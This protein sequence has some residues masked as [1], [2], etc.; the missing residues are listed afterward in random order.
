ME[1]KDDFFIT[2]SRLPKNL[3]HYELSFKK[4]VKL[5][6]ENPVGNLGKLKKE[7]KQI[8]KTLVTKEPND[9]VNQYIQL[10]YRRISELEV[11]QKKTFGKE[12][13][14]ELKQLGF[15]LIGHY[16]LLRTSFYALE[17]NFDKD[18]VTI[19]FGPRQEK[20]KVCRLSPKVV[21]KKL[22]ELH[23]SITKREFNDKDFLLNLY[24]ACEIVASKE[25]KNLEDPLPIVKVLLE[26]VTLVKNSKF[27]KRNTGYERVFFIYDLFRLKERNINKH[28]LELITATRAYTRKKKDFLW[29]PMDEDGGGSYIS[30]VRFRGENNE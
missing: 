5:L 1:S 9:Q 11:I 14:A 29:V 18:T 21:A 3:N 12:L 6:N 4:I 26:Y 19:W 15:N 17:V 20:L 27:Q 2:L 22:V 24:K 23:N 8:E 10:I 7:L 25:K 13:E 16:P 28:E 30:H